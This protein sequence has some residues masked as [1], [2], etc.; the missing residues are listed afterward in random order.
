MYEALL[1]LFGP[2][3]LI[4]WIYLKKN[5]KNKSFLLLINALST[6][7]LYPIAVDRFR[8]IS[9]AQANLFTIILILMQDNNL[10]FELNKTSEKN[11]IIVIITFIHCLL[12]G[13]LEDGLSF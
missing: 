11:K 1:I 3:I 7:L 5:D 2:V 12:L 4:Y 10:K 9:I 8:W 6:L 13:P